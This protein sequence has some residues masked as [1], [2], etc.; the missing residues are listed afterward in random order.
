[1]P[2]AFAA[3]L[4]FFVAAITGSKKPVR[5]ILN[6]LLSVAIG[7]GIGAGLGYATGN[8]ST[9]GTTAGFLAV[10]LGLTTSIREIV[11]NRKPKKVPPASPN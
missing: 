2:V 10:A 5:T 6:I 9:G 4:I 3:F 11:A 1:M 7:L 8:M